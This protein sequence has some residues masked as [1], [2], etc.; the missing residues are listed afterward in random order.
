MIKGLACACLASLALGAVASAPASAEVCHK[1]AGSKKYVLCVAGE[2]IGSPTEEK[3]VKF[4]S[5]L[6][7]GTSARI[8]PKLEGVEVTITCATANS[9]GRLNSGGSGVAHI[10]ELH[11][12]F[13]SCKWE[14]AGET[15]VVE[16]PDVWGSETGT[17]GAKAENITFSASSGG[18]F[19]RMQIGGLNCR[20]LSGEWQFHGSPQCTIGEVEVET[21]EKKIVCKGENSHLVMT[22]WNSPTELSL[23]EATSLSGTSEGKKFS[24]IE[25]A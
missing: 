23:E 8:H 5:H 7:T 18:V 14:E 1:K 3:F 10:S 13:S 17:F 19:G 4:K 15:C 21:L 2:R 11:I 9:E 20:V 6:V 12:T 24:I 25:S 16:E 22:P